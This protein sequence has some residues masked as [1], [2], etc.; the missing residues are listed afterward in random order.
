MATFINL[1]PH[2]VNVVLPNGEELV[3]IST[4]IARVAETTTQIGE[5]DGIP[6]FKS[7]YGQV[8]GLPEPAP[9]T[10]YIVS[11][12]VTDALP[13]RRDLFIPAVTVRDEQGRIIG[14]K[15]LAPN[16]HCV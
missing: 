15:G 4:G 7:T 9:N 8:Q 1:T 10:V 2:A 13:Q 16:P 12:M 3:I 6:L 11:K 5:L 14:C